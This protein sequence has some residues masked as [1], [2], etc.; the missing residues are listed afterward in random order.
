MVAFKDFSMPLSVFQV[1]FKANLICRNFQDS[2]VYSSTFHT[3][4]KPAIGF[5]K[6]I[7]SKRATGECSIF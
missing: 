5:W 3:C 6:K 1:L 2:H 4:E 7:I